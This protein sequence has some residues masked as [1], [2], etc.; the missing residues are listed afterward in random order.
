M[1]DNIL[2]TPFGDFVGN[3]GEGLV[4]YLGIQYARLQD[5]LAKPEMVDRYDDRVDATK[6]G[7]RVISLEACQFEQSSLI[8][9]TLDTPPA[10]PMSDLDCL[11]L[12]ITTP[13]RNSEELLPVM[14]FVHGGGYIMGANWWPQ[15][16]CT[17]LVKLSIQQ[18]T[19]V[20][21]INFNYRLAVAG[22]L[23]SEELRRAGYPGN[24]SLRDQRCALN[25]IKT[26]ITAFGGDSDNITLFGESAGAVSVLTH[27]F[28]K[29]ALFNRAISM[30]GTPLMLKPLSPS[31]A[32]QTYN[33]IMQHLGLENSTAEERIH[34]LLTMNPDE[35]VQK[36]PM[37]VP[38]TPYQDGDIIPCTMTFGQV[39]EMIDSLPGSTWCKE[40]LIGHCKH[41]GNVFAYMGLAER[42]SGIAA[43]FC[44][45]F[46]NS[47]GESAA[48]AIFEGYGL[49][50]ST[51]DEV[52]WTIVVLFASDI[53]Y[54]LPAITF[55]QS[56]PGKAYLYRFEEPNPWDGLF[57]GY[58][59]HMLDA[60]FL[61]QNFNDQLAHGARDTAFALAKDFVAFA[62]GAGPWPSTSDSLEPG[63][64]YGQSGED[65]Q[66]DIL[67][68][69]QREGRIS[70]D[71]VN[72]AWEKFLTNKDC[73]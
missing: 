43:A 25:W 39:E 61:F 41:D 26:H 12:N 56:F 8:Q 37:T 72:A 32:E 55:A 20:V 24:N 44:K 13:T 21:A 31:T 10:P 66:E 40:L 15:Y 49:S 51:S 18:G 63:K 17:N 36:T 71:D 47:L 5:R 64:V 1:A 33:Q 38:L 16:D 42:R 46:S 62:H 58:S 7:P 68:R 52:A 67:L 22:N 57:K 2:K 59:T 73:L 28:S 53:A 50:P 35:L 69:L 29:D 65:G 60:A 45:S 54:K 34:R 9:Q 19:P 6:I 23:T 30:S 14:V 4:Q 3:D 48:R 27:L 70:L 11:N